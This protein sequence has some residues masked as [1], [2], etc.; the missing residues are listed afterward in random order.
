MYEKFTELLEDKNLLKERVNSK[1]EVLYDFTGI[2]SI[3]L[4]GTYDEVP[5]WLLSIIDVD[6]LVG[7]NMKLFT[8][9]YSPLSLVS[10]KS[11]V[12]GSAA[13]YYTNIIRI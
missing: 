1:G 13:Q 2:K 10:G 6:T 4:P 11:S 8:Q 7:D 5:D 9:I 12:N 3:A